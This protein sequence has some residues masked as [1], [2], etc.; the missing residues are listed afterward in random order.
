[1]I[2]VHKFV[3]EEDKAFIFKGKF[4][5]HEVELLLIKESGEL[6]INADD[7]SRILG[8]Q[9]FGDLLSENEE[10]S[11]ALLDD[12]NE[13]Y[14]EFSNAQMLIILAEVNKIDDKELRASLI[15]KLGV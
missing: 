4:Q 10:M 5:E 13:D 9:D 14:V 15:K 2:P 1:M 7:V 11:N 6:M 12:L 3:K 8:N